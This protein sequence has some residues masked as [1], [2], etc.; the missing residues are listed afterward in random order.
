MG[1]AAHLAE[2]DGT[3]F[4]ADVLF[5]LIVGWL[6]LRWDCLACRAEQETNMMS[7]FIITTLL[8]HTKTKVS[9]E[10]LEGTVTFS[11]N[12]DTTVDLLGRCSTFIDEKVQP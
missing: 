5:A 12:Y 10:W 9:S 6:G 8:S 7:A 11:E 2:V 4:S 1:P 3:V